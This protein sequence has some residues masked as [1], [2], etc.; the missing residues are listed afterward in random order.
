MAYS[1]LKEKDNTTYANAEYMLD[2]MSEENAATLY[3]LILTVYSGDK[4]AREYEQSK[5][6][7]RRKALLNLERLR[8]EIQEE[9]GDGFDPE[10]ELEAGLQEKYGSIA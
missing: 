4:V 2:H 6:D 1:T 5:I 7:K 3:K 10:R 9:L 8:K